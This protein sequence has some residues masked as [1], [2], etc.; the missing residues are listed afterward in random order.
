MRPGEMTP[1]AHFSVVAVASSACALQSHA[2]QRIFPS[3]PMRSSPLRSAPISVSRSPWMSTLVSPAV[4]VHVPMSAG[5]MLPP[6]SIVGP[7]LVALPLLLLDDDDAELLL[8]LFPDP[9]GAQLH[10]A[11]MTTTMTTRALLRCIHA[12]R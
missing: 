10:I 3:A 8:A 11:A 5:A 12:R 4:T 9:L 6:Q 7:P 2:A 1:S